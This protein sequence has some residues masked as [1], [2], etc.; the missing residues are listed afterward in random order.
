[1]LVEIRKISFGNKGDELMLYAILERM[2]GYYPDAKFVLAEKRNSKNS[3]KMS[4]FGL[5]KKNGLKYFG[6]RRSLVNA[7]MPRRMLERKGVVRDRDIDVVLDATGF[8][9]GDQWPVSYS[10]ELAK[11]CKRW[12]KHGTRVI[13]MPKAFGPFTSEE[14]KDAV[15][16]IADNADLI[17]ARE[18]VSHEHLISAAGKRPNIQTAPDFTNLVEGILPGNFDTE[19]NR[20]CII[21]NSHM[22]KRTPKEQSEAYV[23]FMV[24][25][26]R[27]LM[28]KKA[29]PF[30][31]V[32]TVKQD[33]AL[34]QEISEG[35]DF[36]LPIVQEPDPLKIKG[37]LGACE[38]TIGSRY[39][40]LV[41]TLSQCIPSLA[42]GWSHKYKMLLEDYGFV[43]GL[44]D[45]T[46]NEE[47]I[48]RKIDL[49]TNAESKE[50][51]KRTLLSR[52]SEL[53]SLSAAMWEK[54]RE[55]IDN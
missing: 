47:E 53:K 39:H 15:K 40:G 33:S 37:I 35:V 31:M 22:V 20:F 28:E 4:E 2:K 36:N 14:M 12:K 19:N 50:R 41:S 55:I 17:F 9:Y 18:R 54:V 26:A 30:L 29:K 23:P 21:P 49:I 45:V 51:V 5:F 42:T 11:L 43:E 8:A 24:K 52:S 44:V 25:C 6:L 7:L 10:V 32:Q 27:Y 16:T 34:V 1:M 38:G 46:A 13:L 3:A 48:R